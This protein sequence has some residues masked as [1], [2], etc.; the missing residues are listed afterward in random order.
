MV[1]AISGV[2]RPFDEREND[3]WFCI[4]VGRCCCVVEL[5]YVEAENAENAEK[6]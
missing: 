5:L 2:G 6:M 1:F 3:L 4:G